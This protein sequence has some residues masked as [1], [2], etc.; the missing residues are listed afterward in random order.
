[1]S[2]IVIT[3]IIDVIYYNNYDRLAR[4]Y[5][6]SSNWFVAICTAENRPN[7]FYHLDD[8]EVFTMLS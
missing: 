6:D 5:N 2:F 3:M 8:L 7:D 1:M 4:H